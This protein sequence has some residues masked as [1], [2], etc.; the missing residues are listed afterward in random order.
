M[1]DKNP[2]DKEPTTPKEPY[3]EK[4]LPE[5]AKDLCE[6]LGYD[7]PAVDK[8]PPIY[9]GPAKAPHPNNQRGE[10]T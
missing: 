7:K 10:K 8:T 2:S 9:P 3:E 4:S 6:L 1:T 5:L